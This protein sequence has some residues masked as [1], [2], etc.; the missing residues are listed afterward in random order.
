MKT[1]TSWETNGH[2]LG[3]GATSAEAAIDCVWVGFTSFGEE[4]AA[5]GGESDAETGA[6]V[7]GACIVIVVDKT[8][9]EI[10]GLEWL[11]DSV[12][13]RALVEG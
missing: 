11:G 6:F 1:L 9:A 5:D 7:G 10:A 8:S 2:S 13:S 12:T 3:F 4:G